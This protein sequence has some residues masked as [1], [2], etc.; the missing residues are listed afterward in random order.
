MTCRSMTGFAQVEHHGQQ[1]RVQ[2]EIRTVNHRF[3]E[4]VVRL[5]REWS[6]LESDV[7]TWV[8][9]YVGRGRAEVF[10]TIEPVQADSKQVVVDWV[11]FDALVEAHHQA[12]ARMRA[13]W[14]GPVRPPDVVESAARWLAMP[15]VTTVR[16]G[17]V[18]AAQVREDVQAAIT[19]ACTAL[20][21][22]RSREGAR[23]A[24]DL[25]QKLDYLESLVDALARQAPAV[26]AQVKTR[27][28]E[29]MQALAGEFDESRWLSEVAV[30]LDR[31]AVDEEIVRLRSHLA[32]CRTSLAAGSPIGRRLDFLVQEMHREVNTIAAKSQDAEISQHVVEMKALVEKL[33]EQ[34][35]NVE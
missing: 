19:E 22:M 14:D 3:A 9:Q 15:D 25:S 21:A 1:A 4:V 20:V 5:P 2:V 6:A 29:R 16:R 12:A 24:A 17:Q 23:L 10:L 8:S 11:L 7:R 30:L 32:E 26:E 31:M 34:A 18:D 27:L 35:Q 13:R 28:R 33:R